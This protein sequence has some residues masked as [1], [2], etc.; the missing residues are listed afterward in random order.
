MFSFLSTMP[1]DSLDILLHDALQASA[2]ATCVFLGW[3]FWST[4]LQRMETSWKGKAKL[5]AKLH[6]GVGCSAEVLNENEVGTL[7]ELEAASPSSLYQAKG[8]AILEHY[9]VFGA[10]AGTWSQYSLD[11][12]QNLKPFAQ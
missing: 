9:H 12:C 3:L 5:A 7:Q 2:L 11:E 8:R 4:L 1:N 6:G 10:A